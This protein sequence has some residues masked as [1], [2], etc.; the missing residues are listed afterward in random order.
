MR[1]ILGKE[2]ERETDNIEGESVQEQVSERV[3][4]GATGY[5]VSGK[6]F[7]NTKDNPRPQVAFLINNHPAIILRAVYLNHRVN[8]IAASNQFYWRQVDKLTTFDFPPI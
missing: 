1:Y 2:G 8:T 5:G 7:V 3:W 6:V 4:A